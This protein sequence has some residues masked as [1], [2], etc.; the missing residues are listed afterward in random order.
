[1]TPNFFRVNEVNND[2]LMKRIDT[3]AVMVVY[4]TI[5]VNNFLQEIFLPSGMPDAISNRFNKEI[6]D[7][8]SLGIKSSNQQL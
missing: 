2:S 7:E 1:M 8:K 6:R 4:I 3:M 5:L